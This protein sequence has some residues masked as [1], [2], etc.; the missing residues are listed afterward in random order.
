M[1]I[2]SFFSGGR[3][4]GA[5]VGIIS[6]SAL[7]L[8]LIACCIV[9]YRRIVRR[10]GECRKISS[11]KSIKEKDLKKKASREMKEKLPFL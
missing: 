3:A 8:L 11:S 1:K 6:G 7:F 4:I 5:I 10:K 2:I 9:Y